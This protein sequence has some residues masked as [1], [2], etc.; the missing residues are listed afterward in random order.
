[1]RIRYQII[2]HFL[3][4]RILVVRVC[5]RFEFVSLHFFT[6]ICYC[7]C[8]LKIQTSRNG[9][10]QCYIQCCWSASRWCRSGYC[11]SLWCGSGSTFHFDA[12]PDPGLS[13]QKAKKSSNR[14]IFHTFWLVMQIDTD[15]DL[16]PVYHRIRFQLITL[17]Q[18]RILPFILMQIRI[19]NTGLMLI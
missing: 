17:M 12:D 14:L 7:W 11:L 13:F 2:W 16:D 1:L 5:F 10:I 18:I 6:P 4:R 19:H 9:F 3:G 8:N 15:P